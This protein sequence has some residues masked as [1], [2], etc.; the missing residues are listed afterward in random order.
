MFIPE[1]IFLPAVFPTLGRLTQIAGAITVILPYTFLY[2]SAFGDPGIIT[3]DNHG[4]YMLLYPYDHT[5]FH[6]GRY[7]HT[8][9]FLKVS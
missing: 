4:Y 1:W 5:L 2:L 9:K 3:H 8:C 6:P 7:C